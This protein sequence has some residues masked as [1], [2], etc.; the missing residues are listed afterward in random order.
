[1]SFFDTT[2]TST[3]FSVRHDKIQSVKEGNEPLIK[4]VS[5]RSHATARHPEG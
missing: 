4:S 5:S 3:F 2:C 1:M